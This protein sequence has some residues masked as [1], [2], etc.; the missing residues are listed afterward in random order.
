TLLTLQLSVA[1]GEDLLIAIFMTF[2]L[3]RERTA[4]GLASTTH[5]LQRLTVFAVNTGIWPATFA[6]LTIVLVRV[7]R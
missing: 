1:A 4:N 3:F 2:L 7:V 6:I 5:I